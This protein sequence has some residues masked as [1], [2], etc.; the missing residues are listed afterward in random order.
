MVRLEI[1]VFTAKCIELIIQYE[2]KWTDRADLVLRVDFGMAC[3][4]TQN[5]QTFLENLKLAD[6]YC[7]LFTSNGYL[8]VGDC[9]GISEDTLKRI[10]ITLPGIV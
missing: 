3:D 10:G 8:T 6:K 1:F 7:N 5:I 4:P 9:E 2:L